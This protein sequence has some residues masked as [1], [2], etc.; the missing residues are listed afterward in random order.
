MLYPELGTRHILE[1]DGPAISSRAPA[2]NIGGMR[3]V[4]PN[5]EFNC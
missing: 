3:A 4:F 5:L 1:E 2:R